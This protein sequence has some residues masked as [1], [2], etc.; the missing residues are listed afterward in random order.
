MNQDLK[1]CPAIPEMEGL[2][3]DFFQILEEAQ[4]GDFFQPH[5]F[6][7]EQAAI[8]ANYPGKDF[9]ALVV[10]K[11][12]MIGYGL[13]RGWDEGHDIPSLG[14]SIHPVFRGAGI[15]LLLMHYLHAVATLK[16]AVNMRLRVNKINHRAKQLYEKLGY[17][18]EEDNED[19]LVGFLKLKQ[20]L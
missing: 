1:I 19:Y 11:G 20:P 5:P 3:A 14:I 10:Y 6:T 9:Y 16:G 13:L 4:E 8:I 7:S 12:K 18:F 15:G 17:V 2:I